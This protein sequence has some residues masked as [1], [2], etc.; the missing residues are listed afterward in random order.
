MKEIF[1][2]IIQGIIQGA[3]EFLPV[4]SSGHLSLTQHFLGIEEPGMLFDVLLHMGT[5]V[6]VCFVYYKLLFRLIKSFFGMVKKIFTGKFRWSQMDA[7]ENLVMMLII[8]LVPLFL[9]FFPVPGTGK[10]VK[11]FADLWATDSSI[12]VSYTHLAYLR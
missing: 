5:L 4:S 7:D 3:T 1:D 8:G 6:A 10:S 9:M 11:D 12:P 2:A